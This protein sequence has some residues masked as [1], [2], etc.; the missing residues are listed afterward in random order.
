MSTSFSQLQIALV[1]LCVTIGWLILISFL[2]GLGILYY[3]L[4]IASPPQ[5]YEWIKEN[6]TVFPQELEEI[7]GNKEMSLQ[8]VL[9]ERRDVIKKLM[10]DENI[11]RV[12]QIIEYQ[13]YATKWVKCC[14]IIKK[15]VV[16]NDDTKNRLPFYQMSG[17]LVTFNAFN[18]RHLMHACLYNP[19]ITQSVDPLLSINDN[20]PALA[21][22]FHALFNSELSHKISK[23]NELLRKAGKGSVGRDMC[24]KNEEHIMVSYKNAQELAEILN[25]I[26]APDSKSKIPKGD[27][28]FVWKYPHIVLPETTTINVLIQ[29][30][31]NPF[32]LYPIREKTAGYDPFA[33][34][35]SPDC[36][37]V[38]YDGY[39]AYGLT[40]KPQ[41]TKPVSIKK[42]TTP[43]STIDISNKDN[44]KD[45][46]NTQDNDTS[47]NK[48]RCTLEQ[49][50]E[51]CNEDIGK[52]SI[53][54]D[55]L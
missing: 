21:R 19:F 49:V 39:V 37:K 12:Q 18:A 15:E 20:Y 23:C 31:Y 40:A 52:D 25:G 41:K 36:V 43:E 6:V 55:I 30:I 34:I 5:K 28:Y 22:D 35:D 29:R 33:N 13:R 7:E 3:V 32:E 38:L 46:D 9:I 8:E 45:Q 47:I 17:D 26:V 54:V 16:S 2:L 27:E 53:S 50:K 11:T 44:D 48:K 51:A 24:T 4:Y 14:C 1:V 42:N 10:N